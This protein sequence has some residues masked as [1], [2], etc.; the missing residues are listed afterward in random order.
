MTLEVLTEYFIK[1]GA[2]AIFIIVFME[3]L[4]LPGFPAGIIMPLSG[5]MAAQGKIHFGIVMLLSS[6]AGLLGSLVL[7]V[8]GLLF[9][10][11]FFHQYDKKNRKSREKL[12]KCMNWLQEKG[13]IGVFLGKL[14]PVLRTI[15]SIP[16]GFLR[17]NIW[18][19]SICSLLGIMI[20]N[21]CF[22]GAGY[23]YGE[24]IFELLGK[25]LLK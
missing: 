20:W 18:K 4:N 16:A 25:Y 7:Y 24:E 3:Y 2:I 17:L 12:E 5:I 9:G 8:M 14:I 22:I 15:I 21:F 10:K 13:Y 19:Y 6:L 23:I 1:Y 11:V